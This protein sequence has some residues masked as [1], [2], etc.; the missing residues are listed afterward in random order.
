[1][2]GPDAGGGKCPAGGLCERGALSR[3]GGV[4]TTG[5]ERAGREAGEV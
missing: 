2:N 1:M 4:G 5:S 3:Y